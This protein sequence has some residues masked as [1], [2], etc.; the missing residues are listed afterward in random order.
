MAELFDR[1]EEQKGCKSSL[2]Q[3]HAEIIR[4]FASHFDIPS[5][6]EI[7]GGISNLV[8][9]R[10]KGTVSTASKVVLKYTNRNVRPRSRRGTR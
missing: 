5:V 8:Q 2:H 10:K 1:G 4:R 3:M 9:A 6:T 7:A